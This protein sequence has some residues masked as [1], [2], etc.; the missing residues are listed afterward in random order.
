LVNQELEDDPQYTSLPQKKKK[1][2][3]LS[4]YRRI[5][6]D[7]WKNE[8]DEVKGEIQGIFD[9]EHEVKADGNESEEDED[10]DDDNNDD[11]DDEKTLL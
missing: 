10:D 9:E 5:R 7:C 6:A 2:H 4:V 3:Q 11:D 8:S 1:A